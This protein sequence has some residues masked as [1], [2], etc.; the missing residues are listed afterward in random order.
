M[1]TFDD[2]KMDVPCQ[3][4]G[5]KMPQTIATLKRNPLLTCSHCGK[6][7]QVKADDL[8]RELDK[9]DRALDDLKRRFR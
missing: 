4:C 3:K 6:Q 7:T 1:G 8:K 2:Q 5:H 9:V